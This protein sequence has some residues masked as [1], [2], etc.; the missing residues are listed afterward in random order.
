MRVKR[1]IKKGEKEEI[2][3]IAVKQAEITS[4]DYIEWQISYLDQD[5]LVEFGHLLKAFYESGDRTFIDIVLRHK[6][7]AVGYQAMVFIYIPET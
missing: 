4:E 6:Q 7:R 5:D 3:P 2:V 1:V